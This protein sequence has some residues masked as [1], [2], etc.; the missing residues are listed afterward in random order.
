MLGA[1]IG[2]VCIIL[3]IAFLFW[4]RQC[5]KRSTAALAAA[6][7]A[8]SVNGNGSIWRD[9]GEIHELEPLPDSASA[10]GVSTHIP[11]DVMLHL[12]TKVNTLF[13]SKVK[14]TY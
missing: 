2:L 5:A 4:R 12:D 14:L 7:A 11:T 13:F 1:S 3:C 6:A 8:A 9:S 10:T